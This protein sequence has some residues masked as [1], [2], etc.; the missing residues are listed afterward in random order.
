MFVATTSWT[1]CFHGKLRK[2]DERLASFERQSLSLAGAIASH[3][4]R[5]PVVSEINQMC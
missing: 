5:H 3:P 4:W 1:A 2:A